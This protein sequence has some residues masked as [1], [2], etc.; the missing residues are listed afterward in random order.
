[1]KRM[2]VPWGRDVVF[3]KIAC[4]VYPDIALSS[5]NKPPLFLFTAFRFATS[6][7]RLQGTFLHSGK[8]FFICS[9][10][11]IKFFSLQGGLE[12][13]KI[14]LLCWEAISIKWK[15]EWKKV[16]CQWKW[17]EGNLVNA[18]VPFGFKVYSLCFLQPRDLLLACTVLSLT[19]SL[20]QMPSA[21]QWQTQCYETFMSLFCFPWLSI[22]LVSLRW[23]QNLV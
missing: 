20:A 13:I 17:G 15:C 21:L 11:Y 22:I 4:P 5:L 1:M 10:S 2:W 12:Y 7:T 23:S 8:S 9:L 16:M 14:H 6:W 18:K 19:T 3:L